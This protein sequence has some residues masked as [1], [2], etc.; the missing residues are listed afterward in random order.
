MVKREVILPRVSATPFLEYGVAAASISGDEHCG[1]T[2]LVQDYADGVLVAVMDGLGHGALAAEAS[3]R[4]R[5]ALARS[6][7]YSAIP[8]IRSCHEALVGTRGVVLSLALFNVR[9]D[10]MTWLGVGNVTGVLMRADRSAVPK[11]ETILVRSGI[12]GMRLPLLR[13][14]VVIVHAGDLLVFATDGIRP[15]FVRSLSV[16]ES[17]QPLAD[18]VLTSFGTDTDDALVLAARYQGGGA[19]KP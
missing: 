9:E 6:R 13:A 12:V 18:R 2:Y 14:S 5:E 19:A 7:H 10:T 1:D 16:S 4:A 11:Q 3:G 17:P 15:D 8:L